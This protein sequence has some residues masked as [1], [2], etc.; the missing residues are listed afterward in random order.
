M[1]DFFGRD[2]PIHLHSD[3][4]QIHIILEGKTHFHIDQNSYQTS[5]AALFYTPPATPHAF[6][7]EPEAHGYVLTIHSSILN[8]I[9]DTSSNHFKENLLLLPSCVEQSQLSD[10][11]KDIFEHVLSLVQMLKSEW[12]KEHN[13]KNGIIESITRII[14]MDVSRLSDYQI[15]RNPNGRREVEQFRA[16]NRLIEAH[17]LSEKSLQFYCKHL[18]VNESRLNYLCKKISGNGPKMILNNRVLLEAKRFLIHTNQ[19]LNELA[20]NLGY[21]DP[22]YFSRFFQ[23]KTGLTPS[24]FRRINTKHQ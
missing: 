5:N 13:F 14:L 10:D 7:T 8:R 20:Y 22:S 9:T 2:M 18:R 19:N 23:V 1:A 21:A 17:Y 4:A 3:F 11:K 12:T 15:Q 6:L 24:D 16:F